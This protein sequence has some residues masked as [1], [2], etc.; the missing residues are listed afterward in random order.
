MDRSFL[1]QVVVAGA[2]HIELLQRMTTNDLHHLDPGSAQITVFTNEKGRIVDRVHLLRLSERVRLITGPGNSRKV[3]EWLKKFIFIEDVN[4]ADVSDEFGIISIFGPRSHAVVESIFA[5]IVPASGAQQVHTTSWEH[6]HVAIYQ[7][8]HIGVDEFNIIS[9]LSVLQKARKRL[10][11]RAITPLSAEVYRALRIEAGWP[12]HGVDFGE[13]ENPHEAAM[14][15]YVNFEKGCYIGQEVVA[16]LDTYDKVQKHLMGVL[17]GGD[18][19]PDSQDVITSDGQKV[20]YVT[21]TAYSFGL[22]QNIALGYVKTKFARAN[23]PVMVDSGSVRIFGKLVELPF[24][25]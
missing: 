5:T 12:E 14:L 10:T 7:S 16:R 25:I 22:G 1:G 23:T 13:N 4:V 19:L 18:G 11:E 2:D 24:A 21:S 17:L 8:S 3:A 9:S 20:G 6:T 15:P